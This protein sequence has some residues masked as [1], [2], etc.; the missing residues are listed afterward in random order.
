M[1]IDDRFTTYMNSLAIDNTPLLQEIEREALASFVPII[2]RETQEYLKFM[3]ALNQ[4]GRI[5]EVGAAVG[6]SSILMATYGPA[7]CT[8]DTI[9][10]YAPRI[11]VARENI[12]R[13]GFEDRITLYEGDAQDILGT[14][15]GS[16][17][18]IF[19]DAAKGQYPIFFPMIRPLMHKGTVMITD[20]VLQDGDII[21]SHYAVNRRNRTIHK[22]VRDYLYELSHDEEL[23][24][25][26]LPIGDG[27]C[28]TVVR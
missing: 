27:L 21:E 11:P 13:A 8:I 12:K 17:D 28:V 10:N 14:L 1:I 5:L 23:A 7:N 9:E 24:F 16:Y 25:S 20:N 15:S 6:F 4:P 22:R 18:F 2:R 26:L 19:M 3:L